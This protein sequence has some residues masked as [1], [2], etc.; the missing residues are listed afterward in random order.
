MTSSSPERA[1]GDIGHEH[2]DEAAFPRNVLPFPRLNRE[3]DEY[4]AEKKSNILVE[5]AHKLFPDGIAFPNLRRGDLHFEK[6]RRL[7]MIVELLHGLNELKEE[8]ATS[9]KES[10]S[11]ATIKL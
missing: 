3:S 9:P 10:K 6:R 8:T 1:A 7:N 2:L 11:K 5:L 4:P